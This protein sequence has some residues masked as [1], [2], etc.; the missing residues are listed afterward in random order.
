MS[1][2]KI[3]K[4]ALVEDVAYR[5]VTSDLIF[6]KHSLARFKIASRQD[7]IFFGKEI[8]SE[9]FLQLKNYEKFKNAK[10]NLKIIVQDGDVVKAGKSIVEGE[11]EVKLIFAAERVILNLIQHLS[12]VA[13]VTNAFVRKLNNKKIK[14]L[15]TRKTLPM[16]RELQKQAVK[17]GGGFNHRFNLADLILI[18]DNHI[19]AASSVAKALS[20]VRKSQR[21]IEIECDNFNQVV[22][23]V[24]SRPDIIMLDNMKIA[25]IKKSSEF[26]RKNSPIKIEVSGGVNLNNIADFSDLDIDFISVGALTHSV[27]AMD[28]GLDIYD[29]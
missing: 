11:G 9:V 16:L 7:I 25:E 4:S 18:K 23:A 6:K 26:I 19:A 27:V 15:D 14:I 22:E 5:D 3:V 28:I 21:K 13:T 17:A 29:N 10:L 8:I 12:G 1:I 24:K 2:K 20:L